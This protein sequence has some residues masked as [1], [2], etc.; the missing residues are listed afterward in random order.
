MITRYN[1]S[2]KVRCKKCKRLYYSKGLQKF[3][4]PY[5]AYAAL[6]PDGTVTILSLTIR[7][8]GYDD[9][10]L[11]LEDGLATKAASGAIYFRGMARVIAGTLKNKRFSVPIGISSPKSEVWHHKSRGLIRD[12]LNS[13]QGLSPYDMSRDA[14]FG[15]VIDNYKVIDGIAFVARVT[16]FKSRDGRNRNR[17]DSV[18]T[19]SDEIYEK[20]L[21][22][23]TF[24][25][26]VKA[27]PPPDTSSPF[28]LTA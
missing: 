12:I 19:K 4:C 2:K 9:P 15:R 13:A 3:D 18:L 21:D 22:R 26:A 6:I 27:A 23:K 1:S 17:I 8:G 10:A 24:V 7:P 5:C 14:V 11:C 16:I 20:L 25:P 28:W